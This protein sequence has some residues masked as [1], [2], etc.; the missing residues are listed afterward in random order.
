MPTMRMR[1]FDIQMSHWREIKAAA[2]AQGLTAAC[3]IRLV[4]RRALDQ[5]D[6]FFVPAASPRGSRQSKLVGRK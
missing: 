1:G 3:W 2:A 4:T 6:L 5:P